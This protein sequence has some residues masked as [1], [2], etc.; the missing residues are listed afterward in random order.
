M[1]PISAILLSRHVPDKTVKSAFRVMG[2]CNDFQ[3]EPEVC[4]K[5]AQA[6]CRRQAMAPGTTTW[7]TWRRRRSVYS[8]SRKLSKIIE[9]PWFTNLM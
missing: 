6:S 7:Q 4:V 1:L 5:E 8:P 3:N 9:K 2:I